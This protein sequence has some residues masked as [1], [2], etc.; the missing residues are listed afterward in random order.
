MIGDRALDRVRQTLMLP[1]FE[2]ERYVIERELGSGG[3]GVV[4]LATDRQLGRQVAI[5]VT[6]GI[7]R[8]SMFEERL[9]RE[10]A[11]LAQLEHPGIVP[12][13]DA[14]VLHDGR[15]FVVM[16]LVRGATL[17]GHLPRIATLPQRL[18]LFER[19]CEPLAFAH[20]RGFAHRDI[21]PSNIMIGEFG[22]V[23][24]LDWG[25]ATVL[26]SET[27]TG[28]GTDG[29]MA[30]EQAAGAPLDARADV[31]ALG[32]LLE[33]MTQGFDRDRR[34]DAIV[35]KASATT[36]ADRYENA[37]ALVTDLRQYAM[38]RPVGAYRDSALERLGRFILRYRVA[39][40]LIVA[41]LVMRVVIAVAFGR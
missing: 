20:S 16:K 12:V 27:G 13:H 8:D 18:G 39:A 5:K 2:G 6:R 10:A 38:G 30:P 3:M 9:R 29:W 17:A 32:R 19:I 15:L 31:F 11:L 22:E 41:Y 35:R 21:K 25:L 34:L 37:A 4:Y 33:W 23:L 26:G 36:P 1:D 28:S 14:G 24:V 40:L 7:G